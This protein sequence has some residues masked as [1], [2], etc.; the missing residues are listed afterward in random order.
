MDNNMDP[1]EREWR[2]WLYTAGT[3]K[4]IAFV[5]RMSEEERSN[6]IILSGVSALAANLRQQAR[7]DKLVEA[8]S[9]CETWFHDNGEPGM[10]EY[11]WDIIKNHIPDASKKEAV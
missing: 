10:Q 5:N 7:I 6:D 3:D 4:E 1:W 2:E 11:V 8:L 9:V